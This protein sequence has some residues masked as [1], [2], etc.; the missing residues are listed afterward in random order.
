[1]AVK[2]INICDRCGVREEADKMWSSRVTPIGIKERF[3]QLCPKCSKEYDDFFRENE[4]R[5]K[6]WLGGLK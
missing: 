2:Y 6:A 5:V 3:I 1:M 4:K